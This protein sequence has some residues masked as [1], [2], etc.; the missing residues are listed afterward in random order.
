MFLPEILDSIAL[1]A[2]IARIEEEWNIEIADEEIEPAVFENL[3]TL[4]TFVDKKLNS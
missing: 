2:M 4:T 3:D 1:T